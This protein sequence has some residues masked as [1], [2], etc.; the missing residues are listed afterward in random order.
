MLDFGLAKTIDIDPAV[1]SAVTELGD[2]AG[3]WY[4][5]HEIQRFLSEP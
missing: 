3:T 1:T 2:F 4:Y 5:M